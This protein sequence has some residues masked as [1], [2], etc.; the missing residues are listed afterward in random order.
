MSFTSEKL[1]I[2]IKKN[3]IRM[4]PSTRLKAIDGRTGCRYAFAER[5]VLVY[6]GAVAS[7]VLF[8]LP[9]ASPAGWA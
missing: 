5:H 4:R 1:K 6:H 3:D 9:E 8:S 7:V 2:M